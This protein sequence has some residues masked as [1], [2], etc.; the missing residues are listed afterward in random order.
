MAGEIKGFYMLIFGAVLILLNVFCWQQVFVLADKNY[1]KVVFFDVGQGDAAFIE[2]PQMHQIL[3]DGG[4]GSTV[5]GKLAKQMPFWD[6]SI[7]VVIL[8]HPDLDHMQGVMEV[9]KRYKVDYFLWPGTKKDTP[10]Y[11]ELVELLLAKQ[12]K[13]MQVFSVFEPEKITAGTAEIDILYPF[14]NLDGREVSKSNDTCVVNKVIFGKSAFLFTGDVSSS[15]EKEIVY[16][17]QN[18]VSDVLKVAHHGSRYSSS[19]EFLAAVLP[20]I[21]VISVGA[22]NPYGHPTS[23]VLQRLADFGVE[24]LRTDQK[25]DIIMLSD[26]QDIDV[27]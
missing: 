21:G 23:E 25:G 6:R 4:P 13:K 3:I 20:E 24:S 18:L 17:G 26:G 19:E 27:K 12:E 8:S 16:S 1:L 5:L 14:E 11:R 7:D 22:D 2:T 10:E 9:L 15:I